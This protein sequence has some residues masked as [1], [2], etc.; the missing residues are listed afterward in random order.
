MNEK[1][2]YFFIDRHYSEQNDNGLLII[3]KEKN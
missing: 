2:P 3:K 1:I